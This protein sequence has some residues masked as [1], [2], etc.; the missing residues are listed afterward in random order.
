MVSA[1]PEGLGLKVVQRLRELEAM[2][3]D[4]EEND[5]DPNQLPN[6]IALLKAYRSGELDWQPGLV[7]YWS[8]G[9]QICEPRGF[10]WDELEVIGE[11]HREEGGFWTEGVSKNLI[12]MF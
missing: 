1:E 3:T 10:D 5:D 11:A 4:L 6:I 7:T 2:K 8:K 9:L 12:H